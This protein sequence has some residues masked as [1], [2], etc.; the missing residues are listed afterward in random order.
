MYTIGII[1]GS[2]VYD[3]PGIELVKEI[4]LDTPYGTPS[5]VYRVIRVMDREVVF[6]PRHGSGHSIAPAQVNYR[7]NLWGF[8]QLGVSRILSTGA[9]GGINRLLTPGDVAVAD[10]IIDMT[11][12]RES[13]FY[14]KDKVYHVDFTSP[15]CPELRQAFID[16]A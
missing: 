15:Y 2:G 5:D 12:N 10:Q 13:S 14:D 7:A 3:I 9:V 11:H 8:K 6:L 16:G 1:G 4:P